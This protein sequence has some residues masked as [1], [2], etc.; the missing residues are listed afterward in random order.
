MFMLS[1][2]NC[3]VRKNM[4]SIKEEWK[5]LPEYEGLYLRKN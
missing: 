1:N 2:Y 4:K 3:Q 5:D